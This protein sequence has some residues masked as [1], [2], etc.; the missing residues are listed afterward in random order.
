MKNRFQTLLSNSACATTTRSH[1]GPA[2]EAALT[3]LAPA[4]VLR[5]GGAGGKVALML[6]GVG[7]FVNFS[8]QPEPTLSRKPT[9]VY[10]RF[11]TY[12]DI[13]HKNVFT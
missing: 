2:I 4:E 10:H 6:D 13:S 8:V 11:P 9:N 12:R 5:V 7:S 3:A 1:P